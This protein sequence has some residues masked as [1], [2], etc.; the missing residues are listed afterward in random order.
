MYYDL[1]KGFTAIELII[2]IAVIGILASVAL[3]RLGALSDRAESS[4]L[5]SNIRT[6][7]TA[8]AFEGIPNPDDAVQVNESLQNSIDNGT[9][10]IDQ[11]PINS[12]V[13]DTTIGAPGSLSGYI[14]RGNGELWATWNCPEGSPQ[15]FIEWDGRGNPNDMCI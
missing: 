14:Y 1:Q 5:G 7:T 13:N 4:T 6:L 3:P 9:A 8:V 2:V 11:I 15:P 12:S 10:L